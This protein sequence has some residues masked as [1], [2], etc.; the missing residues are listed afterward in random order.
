MIA[1]LFVETDGCYFGVP[2]VE[3]F[4][5]FRDARTYNGTYPVVAHPPCARWGSFWYGGPILHKLGKRKQKGD[6]DGCFAA[7]LVAVRRCGGVIEHP[8]GSHAWA[9][10]G[11]GKPPATGGWIETAGGWSCCVW[12]GNY[13]HLA[14]KPTWL[15]YV[16]PKPPDLKWG[17]PEG[18]FIPMSGQSFRSKEKKDQA[19]ANGWKYK[20]RIATKMRPRTP[21]Q[22]RDLLLS[23]AR[24]GLT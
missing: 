12:Q 24:G 4:D 7:A 17:R 2:G 22:F 14:L 16:G 11:I 18:D 9:H 23:L 8:R 13:G 5:Q 20:P 15:F 3:P 21:L 19:I 6:D 1:A 10:F